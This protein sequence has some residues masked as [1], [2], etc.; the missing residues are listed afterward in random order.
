AEAIK[1]IRAT[2][3]EL[4]IKGISTNQSFLYMI[5]N[6]PNYIKGKFNTSFIDLNLEALLEYDEYE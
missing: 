6:N 1:K 4:V 5:I 2:L 3:E